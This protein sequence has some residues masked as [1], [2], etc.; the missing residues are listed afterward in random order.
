MIHLGSAQLPD[1]LAW[2]DEWHDSAVGQAAVRRLDG[3]IAVYPRAQSGGRPITL[4]ATADTWLTRAEAAALAALAASAGASYALSFDQR[5]EL[6]TLTVM[7]RH[8]DPPALDLRALVRY[9]GAQADDPVTG[10]IKL[11]TV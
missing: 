2:L 6:G 10:Q 1:D 7:F 5:P 9:E 3:G 11:F 8:Q 4:E